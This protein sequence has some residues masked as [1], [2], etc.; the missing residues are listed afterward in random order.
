M[1][2]ILYQKIHKFLV[3]IIYHR[4]VIFLFYKD[5]KYTEKIYI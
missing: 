1:L 4:Y 5:D 3:K 2:I